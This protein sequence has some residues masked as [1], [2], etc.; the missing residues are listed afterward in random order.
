VFSISRCLSVCCLAIHV[1]L[2]Y[3]QNK[4]NTDH[5]IKEF[6]TLQ[7]TIRFTT[8]KE[9]ESINFLD[10][11]I[12][13]NDTNSE[14]KIYRKP[15]QTDIIIPNSSCHP[16]EHKLSRINYLVNQLYTYPTTKKAKDAEMNTI[17]N[18]LYNNDYN[19]NLLNKLPPTQKKQ[20][21][22]TH[23]DSQQQRTKWAIFTNSGK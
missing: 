18:I 23:N 16:Y 7:P 6:N 12:H 20:K 5:T 11:V 3:D 1:T 10:L 8:E 15:T 2:L 14:F 19:I 9:H 13:R 4:T 22:F 21:Q 17:K